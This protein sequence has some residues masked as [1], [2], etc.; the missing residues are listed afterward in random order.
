MHSKS[1]RQ[2]KQS[3]RQKETKQQ[4]KETTMRYA[5]KHPQ[6]KAEANRKETKQ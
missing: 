4:T 2:K 1:S 5:E 6:R 3:S